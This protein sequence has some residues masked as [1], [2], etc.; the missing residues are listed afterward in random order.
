MTDSI[1]ILEGFVLEDDFAVSGCM[2]TRTVAR[3]RNQPDGLPYM[4]WA[5]R[6][7]IPVDAAREWMRNRFR[8]DNPT[9][10]RRKSE[11]AAA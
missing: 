7:Y 9:K 6:I 8:R 4:E 10:R 1:N 5:G 2:S 11:S 3:Y